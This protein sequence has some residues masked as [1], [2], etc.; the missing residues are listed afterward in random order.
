MVVRETERA[1]RFADSRDQGLGE[2]AVS[3]YVMAW[4]SRDDAERFIGPYDTREGA[5]FIMR[6]V[7]AETQYSAKVIEPM[8]F[9]AWLK[10]VT[11]SQRVE[12]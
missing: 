8:E 1:A 6:R 2:V 12:P 10:L 11:N 5:E 7:E 4:N 3:F 9:N